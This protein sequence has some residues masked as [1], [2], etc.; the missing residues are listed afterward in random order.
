M[1]SVLLLVLVRCALAVPGVGASLAAFPPGGISLVTRVAAAFG[2]GYAVA[3][4]CAFVLSSAHV[5]RL[6]VFIPVWLVASAVLWVLALRPGSPRDQG[7]AVAA[8]K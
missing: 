6:Y 4:G 3:G 5:F 1:Q 7:P 8:R 2:L